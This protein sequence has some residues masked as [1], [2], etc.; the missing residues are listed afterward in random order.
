MYEQ[1][2]LQAVIDGD[3]DTVKYYIN[4]GAKIDARRK[5]TGESALILAS[6]NGFLEIA[7]HLI[8]ERAKLNTKDKNGNTALMCAAYEGHANV[9]QFLLK[10]GAQ[11]NVKNIDDY[12]ALSNAA[13]AG[14]LNIVQYLLKENAQI[15]T[16]NEDVT[17][18]LMSAA[19][20]GHLNIVQ[21]LLKEGVQVDAKEK[22]GQTALMWAASEGHLNIVQY[23]LKEGVQVD[24]KDEDGETALIMA[25]KR[26]HVDVVQFL[27]EKGAQ[28]DAKDNY[29]RTAL[30]HAAPKGR[31]NI[32][33]LLLE[34]EA[35]IHIK[36]KSGC[37]AFRYSWKVLMRS[38]DFIHQ[39]H[40]DVVQYLFEKCANKHIH[41]DT[42]LMWATRTGQTRAM[43][44]LLEKGA[45]VNVT[46]RRGR[47]ALMWAALKCRH[48]DVVTYL[49]KEGAQ[50]DAKDEDG[51]TALIMAAKRGH[52]KAVQSLLEKGAK[53][54]VV[55]IYSKTA[56]MWAALKNHADVVT[57]LLKKGAQV[58]AK[59]E[60]GETAL[61]IA[62][63]SGHVDVVQSLIEK[64]AEVNAKNDCKETAL[65][66]A[67]NSGHVDVMQFLIDK[68]ADINAKNIH[69]ETALI[70]AANSGH[71]DVVQFLIE[72]DADVNAKDNYK[73]TALIK[74]A[75]RG[76][77]DIV[78]L[79]L[80]KGAEVKNTLGRTALIEA[81]YGG[82][83]DVVQ[84]LIE[85][86][87][88]DNYGWTALIRAA[89]N[90]F[91]DA[92]QHL[93]KKDVDIHAKDKS[94]KTA[95]MWA[96][97]WGHIDIV[98]LLLEKGAEVNA[99]D[100]NRKTALMWAAY[101]G[102]VDVVQFLIEKGAEVNA[103]DDNRKTALMRAA[104]KGH[105]DI[106]QFLIE[107]DA[108]VNAEDNNGETAL[109]KAASTGH[110][111]VVQF[112]IEKDAD[113]NAKNNHKETALMKADQHYH[114]NVV[115]VL[116]YK[117]AEVSAKKE[118]GE[119]ALM[120]AIRM[121]HIK[122]GETALMGAIR[123][124][125]IKNGE[126]AL[127]GA[128]RMSSTK[129]VRLFL[130]KDAK[131]NVVDRHGRTA[132]FWA[133]LKGRAVVVQYLLEKGAKVNVVDRHGRTALFWAALKGHANI[134]TYL[135][136]NGAEVNAKDNNGETALMIVVS[137][138]HI[139]IVQYLLENGA[140]IYAENDNGKTA[141]MIAA[142]E[143]HAKVVQSLLE[144]GADINAK[145][146]D[147][148]TALIQASCKG[149]VKVVEL[150]LKNGADIN[151]KD[152]NSESAL[153]IANRQHHENVAH[154]LLCKSA[155]INAKKEH[156]ETG[157][158]WASRKGHINF[159]RYLLEKG[160]E[161]NAKD[162]NRKTA[163]MLAAYSG[164]VDVVQFLIEKG[165]EVNAKNTLGRTALMRAAYGG[166][167]DIVKPLLE[168]GAEVNVVDRYGRT[169]L[170]WA[171]LKGHAVVV[172]YLLEKSAEVNAKDNNGKTALMLATS[173]GHTE[174]EQLL[175]NLSPEQDQDTSKSNITQATPQNTTT[176]VQI[177]KP[178]N[179][180]TKSKN[181][182]VKPISQISG[183]SKN[184][185]KETKR[186]YI[187]HTVAG[188]GNCGYTA[189]GITRDEAIG[190]LTDDDHINSIRVILQP[191][192]KGAL[193]TQSFIDYLKNKEI[194][195]S[196]LSYE[197]IGRDFEQYSTNLEIIKAYLHYDVV[198]K[199][200]SGGWAHPCVLQALACIQKIELRIWCLGD[201]QKLIPHKGPEYD[202]SIYEA[203]QTVASR[204]D[205]LFVNGDHF[206]R[207]TFS[208]Y[209]N[210]TPSDGED[211]Y[212]FDSP[213]SI[214]ESDI[215]QT[216]FQNTTAMSQSLKPEPKTLTDEA[217]N[218]D[219][220]P[221][222]QTRTSNKTTM[223]NKKTTRRTRKSLFPCTLSKKIKDTVSSQ[224][225]R[226]YHRCDKITHVTV[227]MNDI[228]LPSLLEN[229]NIAE[230]IIK[231]LEETDLDSLHET[232][233]SARLSINTLLPNHPPSLVL[234]ID[235]IK[236]TNIDSFLNYKA[237]QK[238]F[239]LFPERSAGVTP[240]NYAIFRAGDQAY[241]KELIAKTQLRDNKQSKA[242]FGFLITIPVPYLENKNNY[243]KPG[244][245]RDPLTLIRKYIK[246]INALNPEIELTKL[247]GKSLSGK[248]INFAHERIRILI[249]LNIKDN[250]Y[251]Y[252][253]RTSEVRQKVLGYATKLN[254]SI[255]EHKYPAWVIPLVWGIDYEDGE[256]LYFNSKGVD[257]L[258]SR[259]DKL[260][261]YLSRI[262]DMP[263]NPVSMK[264][265]F[266]SARSFLI[267][268]KES[269]Q[270]LEELKCTNEQVYYKTSDSDLISLRTKDKKTS[271]FT[272][273]T[274]AIEKQPRKFLVRGGGA[275]GF[276]NTDIEN[277]I[278][279][280]ANLNK[281]SLAQSILLTQLL[282]SL[283]NATRKLTANIDSTLP[284]YSECHTYLTSALFSD[285]KFIHHGKNSSSKTYQ[286]KLTQKLRNSHLAFPDITPQLTIEI[287]QASNWLDEELREHK[288][289]Q[290][291]LSTRSAQLLTSSRHDLALV[292]NETDEI[293]E[294]LLPTTQ[295]VNNNDLLNFNTL[296][297]LLD[298][299][300]NMQL[301]ASQLNSRFREAGYGNRHFHDIVSYVLPDN[302][303]PYVVAAL[304]ENK[305]DKHCMDAINSITEQCQTE[306]SL[307]LLNS[308]DEVYQAIINISEYPELIIGNT[309]TDQP[310]PEKW[311]TNSQGLDRHE[312]KSLNSFR[313]L[314]NLLKWAYTMMVNIHE[315]GSSNTDRKRITAAPKTI[316]LSQNINTPRPLTTSN[317]EAHLNAHPLWEWQAH[318]E[319]QLL[320]VAI[321]QGDIAI[322]KL[323]VSFNIN[324]KLSHIQKAAMEGKKDIL[325][326]LLESFST[327]QKRRIINSVNQ[328]GNN[329]L[330]LAMHSCPIDTIESLL[331][332]G[333]N[334]NQSN[335]ENITPLHIAAKTGDIEKLVL[336]LSRGANI[337]DLRDTAT[338]THAS[339][340]PT[341]QTKI[342]EFL[343]R[344]ESAFKIQTGL[345]G[346]KVREKD[347]PTM[348]DNK[349][350][351]LSSEVA[352]LL[353][354]DSDSTGT[355]PMTTVIQARKILEKI[356]KGYLC[357]A[358]AL[359]ND[360]LPHD[361]EPTSIHQT[362][363]EIQTSPSV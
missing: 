144:K 14:H 354:T 112:L 273:I 288:D 91:A 6:E 21:Y 217:K 245:D 56:L 170:F 188:D 162:D 92:V 361:S 341:E 215:L 115:Q 196:P 286:C 263:H 172:Q 315:F 145:D 181:T 267:E 173:K 150:L 221:A 161:V 113:V 18:A 320:N 317:L 24:A 326:T 15:D 214:A 1:K 2:M 255:V 265:P 143:G 208:G 136:K 330:H 116:L 327:P 280:Q 71:I 39:G 272:E 51:E 295:S 77:V 289:Q 321:Q 224:P 227:H 243:N 189:F 155:E 210:D 244:Y 351:E 303:C 216:T 223:Q 282:R 268:C 182:I 4:Q 174:V 185:I 349:V 205:L 141:L 54:N 258:N 107:K 63:N 328:Q 117:S 96:A 333:A 226:E 348:K 331:D 302:Q 191:V 5:H 294:E 22:N 253:K 114:E 209:N 147:G 78:K 270:M 353:K 277:N 38:P 163:L 44:R 177:T 47:T 111:D 137:K 124:G 219:T 159:V 134:V 306:T 230:S 335:Q 262:N 9:V 190:L 350:K 76:H 43:K 30:M 119:T 20:A 60:D 312:E 184:R 178:I 278:K 198:D 175:A 8:E 106:V 246:A 104:L 75:R 94:G 87:A 304:S 42:A 55:N 89:C 325:F 67:A 207:L 101:S 276:K 254:E 292:F 59:D 45:K 339:L 287:G 72:K 26:G 233:R 358:S 73:G 19:V 300:H 25:A 121:G 176:S 152:M 311:A 297:N 359:L 138:G 316:E 139:D 299:Q 34:K 66:K 264:F 151:V 160:A 17:E 241:K 158:M 58:D 156:G 28:I 293:P 232:C 222:K 40:A 352:T 239:S 202:Y 88:E 129:V 165:A 128:I 274:G 53:V 16:K 99:K 342:G 33:K 275:H 118:H 93:L 322:V 86:D 360:S 252:D 347:Y 194:I 187:R 23:L 285:T 296:I 309:N 126:T 220:A 186:G 108:D 146:K 74:A 183:T 179:H 279:M 362:T 95:F 37:T 7:Q 69:K 249:G 169:A 284:Y 125:H 98:K 142:Y 154:V 197:E 80:E 363:V 329:L 218:T 105:V 240:C 122:N 229:L 231:Y 346:F 340:D 212:P 13:L 251:S 100:D 290:C 201:D 166:H 50:I 203:P 164:H 344:W 46:D 123:M 103:K 31:L 225:K 171:A 110:V 283:D 332:L 29:D 62:A 337:G 36:S 314:D 48:A 130:E 247:K 3:I 234:P 192:V 83:V 228:S 120:G 256:E 248:A 319:H 12:T 206:E 70:I 133:A 97:F 131:V 345:R 199:Q 167:I 127:M 132:L 157:L 298:K 310:L 84:F 324:I 281:T 343:T 269:K 238:L 102:H 35:N 242:T 193:L 49:L 261:A 135:L 307:P 195:Q 90:G 355:S 271:V 301:R 81:A 79:L 308:F 32:V 305:S 338:A 291:F 213:R 211:I 64:G 266:A 257:W 336:L 237:V 236:N 318:D 149:H 204:T 356:E 11:V 323:L 41:G 68:G 140:N 313:Q 10:E 82:H 200:I 109:I 250:H 259:A 153:M 57:Y 334:V 168:K 148:K 357:E 52:T 65:I 27:I 260:R 85:K 235:N 61:I 180:A